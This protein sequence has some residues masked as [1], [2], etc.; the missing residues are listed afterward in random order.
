MRE[1][2]IGR[3]V[4][5]VERSYRLSRVS[6]Y[7]MNEVNATIIRPKVSPTEM[8]ILPPLSVKSLD[9]T[10]VRID[11]EACGYDGDFP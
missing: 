2:D 8:T 3:F 10:N 1:N 6:R 5:L 7:R 9:S 4:S 11:K